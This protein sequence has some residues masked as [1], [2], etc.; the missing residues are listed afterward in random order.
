MTPANGMLLVEHKHNLM[1][2]FES[3]AKIVD[4]KSELQTYR[5]A[6]LTLKEERG[7]L[8]SP[9]ELVRELVA[10]NSG[11]IVSPQ[12]EQMARELVTTR[13]NYLN[14]LENDYEEYR[15]VLTNHS[16]LLDKLIIKIAETRDYIDQKALWIR[17]ANPIAFSD[18]AKSK[19]ALNSLFRFDAW[20]VLASAI[21]TRILRRP[22]ET[23]LGGFV[24][25]GLF[26]VSRR[27]K[28]QP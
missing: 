4:I 11:M 19:P 14:D 3:Q 25:L 6:G 7:P 18:L 22:Y 10:Q 27:L 17:N 8:A 28:A 16:N 23:A 2:P 9:D 26:V 24:M 20:R 1:Q 21:K 15:T 12:F 13:L 5:L